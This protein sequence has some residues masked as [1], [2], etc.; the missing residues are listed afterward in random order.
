MEI[1]ALRPK[2]HRPWQSQHWS[3]GNWASE[4]VPVTLGHTTSQ[5]RKP[6]TKHLD[7]QPLLHR[8]VSPSQASFGVQAVIPIFPDKVTQV[9]GRIKVPAPAYYFASILHSLTV[10]TH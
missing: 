2:L 8:L 1:E 4:A 7:R 5:D 10:S 3:L 6:L 9:S